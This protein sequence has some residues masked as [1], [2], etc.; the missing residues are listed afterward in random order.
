MYTKDIP[1]IGY[2]GFGMTNG[3]MWSN[4]VDFC[5][6]DGYNLRYNTKSWLLP[7]NRRKE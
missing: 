3:K 4:F 5:V 2:N 1:E 7:E 6:R